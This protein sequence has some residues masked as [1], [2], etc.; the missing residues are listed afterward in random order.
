MPRRSLT[1]RAGRL[2]LAVILGAALAGCA[3]AAPSDSPPTGLPAVQLS[4]ERVRGQDYA[5]SIPTDWA[6]VHPHA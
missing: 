2:G 3:G 6:Q 5:Y 1:A 4:D